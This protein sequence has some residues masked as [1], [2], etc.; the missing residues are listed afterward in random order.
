MVWL[1]ACEAPATSTKPRP[2][3]QKPQLLHG[4]EPIAPFISGLEAAHPG[5]V[6]VYV[7]ASWCE[8]CRYFHQAL[9]DG[10]LD[11]LLKG[12]HVV[13][14]DLDQSKTELTSAGYS[15]RMIP[16]FAL[17]NPD[18]TASPRMISGSIKGAAAV[19]DNLVPRLRA[20]LGGADAR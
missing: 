18:G 17:P 4:E 1:S 10:K 8:P 13:E 16:L 5:Q 11:E 12:K 2:T 9:V 7:G 3:I 14:Y 19:S 20:L 15:A 6:L